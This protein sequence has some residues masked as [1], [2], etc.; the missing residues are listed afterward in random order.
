MCVF[1]DRQ[2]K[3]HNNKNVRNFS[4]KE[5]FIHTKR[6]KLENVRAEVTVSGSAGDSLCC[7][8]SLSYQLII[9]ILRVV[10]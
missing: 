2:K 7:L 5:I 10:Y 3:T 8:A 1:F 4:D 9:H 6:K